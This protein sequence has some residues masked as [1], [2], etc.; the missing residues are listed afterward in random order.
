LTG[1][2]RILNEIIYIVFELHFIALMEEV[3]QM[4]D[5]EVDGYFYTTEWLPLF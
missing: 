1:I 5:F 2:I 3:L 4:S